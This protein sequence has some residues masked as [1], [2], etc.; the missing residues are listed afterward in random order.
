MSNGRCE[1]NSLAFTRKEAPREAD[2][3]DA[4]QP[5]A[6]VCRVARRGRQAHSTRSA[7][8]RAGWFEAGTE[9]YAPSA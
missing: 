7:E 1:W 6:E 4:K 3:L 5:L 8:T 9:G 2:A